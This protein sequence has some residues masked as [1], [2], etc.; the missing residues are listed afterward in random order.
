MR[1]LILFCILVFFV[2]IPTLGAPAKENFSV[3][4]V[5]YRVI[6]EVQTYYYQTPGSSYTTCYGQ[7]QD[8]GMFTRVNIDCDTTYTLPSTIP[9]TW[10]K[11]HVFNL[12]R[13]PRGQLIIGC[14]ANWRFMEIVLKPSLTG[15]HCESWPTKT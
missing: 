1:R 12:V 11:V 9:M 7:G 10:R 14:T 4:A 15:I 5:A 2:G 3:T 6:P 8:F 13:S